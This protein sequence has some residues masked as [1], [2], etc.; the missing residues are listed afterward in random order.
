[1]AMVQTMQTAKALSLILS[2]LLFIQSVLAES[3]VVTKGQEAPFT[4]ILMDEETARANKKELLELDA[5]RASVP[6]YKENLA[7]SEAQVESWRKSSLE[8][9]QELIRRDKWDS[10]ENGLYFGAGAVIVILLSFAVKKSV[11]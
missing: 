5:L 9:H 4:G 6:L 8:A 1:M 11:N 10:V 2:P 3:V 7:I